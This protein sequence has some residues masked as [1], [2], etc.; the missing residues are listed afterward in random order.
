MDKWF[1]VYDSLKESSFTR[2]SNAK[3]FPIQTKNFTKLF[4]ASSVAI[5]NEITTR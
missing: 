3:I 4:K 5:K 1:V 2:R